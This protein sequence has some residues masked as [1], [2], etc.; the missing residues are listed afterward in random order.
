MRYGWNVRPYAGTAHTIC[1]LFASFELTRIRR[2]IL[3]SVAPPL[4][5]LYGD[6]LLTGIFPSLVRSLRLGHH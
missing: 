1:L 6:H 3:P 2:H 4:K 5:Q